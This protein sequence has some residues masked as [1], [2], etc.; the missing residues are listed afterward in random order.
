MINKPSIKDM[1]ISSVINK[2]IKIAMF[3]DERAK[4]H[5]FGSFSLEL[6]SVH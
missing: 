2:I 5:F 1:S 3:F 6:V 4:F